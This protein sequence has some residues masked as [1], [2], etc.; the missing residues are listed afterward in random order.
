MPFSFC[1][2]AACVSVPAAALP[3]PGRPPP[4]AALRSDYRKPAWAACPVAAAGCPRHRPPDPIGSPHRGSEV[5]D[6]VLDLINGIGTDTVG[7]FNGISNGQALGTST[8][9]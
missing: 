3:S 9:G 5:A 1:S 6:T 8:I 2:T 7:W 4:P